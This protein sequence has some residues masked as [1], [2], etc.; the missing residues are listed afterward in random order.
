MDAN[1]IRCGEEGY[2]L[3]LSGN[4]LG[5]VGSKI[6]PPESEEGGVR[7]EKFKSGSGFAVL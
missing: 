2:D 1:L 4:P 7:V 3:R 5:W 6:H